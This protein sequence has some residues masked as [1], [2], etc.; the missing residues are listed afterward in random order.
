MVQTRSLEIAL[1][2]ELLGPAHWGRT[3][4]RAAAIAFLGDLAA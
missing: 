3:K 4:G 1:G 2:E